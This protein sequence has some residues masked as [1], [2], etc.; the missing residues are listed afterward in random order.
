PRPTACGASLSVVR[1]ERDAGTIGR[2]PRGR[3][4][5]VLAILGPAVVALAAAPACA[6]ARAQAHDA[7]PV[8]IAD[9]A[10]APPRPG[11]T[12]RRSELGGRPGG[13]PLALRGAAP[14]V[15]RDV[16]LHLV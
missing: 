9:V 5:H 14:R 12:G 3:T 10:P 16:A 4:L 15:E 1:R 13:R 7:P 8:V 11:R 6:P 2:M